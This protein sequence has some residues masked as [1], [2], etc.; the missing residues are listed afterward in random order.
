MKNE[1][2]KKILKRIKESKKDYDKASQK[3]ELLKKN[4]VFQDELRGIKKRLGKKFFE[5]GNLDIKELTR[6]FEN[7]VLLTLD[8]PKINY[9]ELD[10]PIDEAEGLHS[11]AQ[12][13]GD[14]SDDPISEIEKDSFFNS[15]DLNTVLVYEEDLESIRTKITHKFRVLERYSE[16]W[17]EFCSKWTIDLSWDGKLSSFSRFQGEL[18]NIG[19]NYKDDD[20]PI[21]IKIG[22]HTTLDDIKVRWHKVETMQ[23]H[24]YERVQKS[25][26]FGRDLCWFD[27]KKEYGL[28][29]GKIAKLWIKYCS[30]DVDFLVI[31]RIQRKKERKELRKEDALELL[32]EIYSDNAMDDVRIQ[33]EEERKIYIEG[34]HSPFIDVIKHAIK[35]M[36]ERIQSYYR[37]KTLFKLA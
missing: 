26:N 35:S 28:S 19:W 34:P 25:S 17:M 10:I 16:K 14:Y 20:W 31:K 23:R 6:I 33:F 4:K 13:Y 27:L 1:V 18:V 12:F 32:E 8:Y 5:L 9:L 37:K 3:A 30:E 36:N 15:P 7:N 21:Y 2:D 29:Y 22:A 11:Q 24:I